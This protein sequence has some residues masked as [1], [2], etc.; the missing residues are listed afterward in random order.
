[1]S[2]S[3]IRQEFADTMLEVGRK[4]KRLVVLVGDI[5]HFRLQ[6]FAKACPGQYYNVGICEQTMVSMAVGLAKVGFYP[7]VH[8]IT[9]FIIERA[10]EQIK[11]DVGYQRIGINLIPIGSAFDYTG[12][13]CT[14]HSYGD[15]ALMKTIENMQIVYPASTIEFN[16]LF[17]QTYRNGFPTYIRIPAVTH[18]VSIPRTRIR[19]G[20]G[21]RVHGGDDLTIVAVGPLLKIAVESLPK[22]ID[23]GISTDLL[24]LPT[25]KPLDAAI[26][27]ASVGKT[28]RC[29]VI[30]EH[31]KYGGVYDDILRTCASAARGAI[32][33]SMNIGDRFIHQ[34]GTYDDFCR[35][36]GFTANG[37][38]STVRKMKWDKR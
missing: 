8:T 34:Y 2:G 26:L 4:D 1:M 6:P 9:P 21:I 38:V 27:R 29:L 5:D 23:L 24:Y 18:G 31:G 32:F 12:L 14:H 17:K 20:K 25:I 16:L 19:L 22:L 10:F 15:F 36:L 33:A 35:T 37:I 13:G 11:D 30:E 28:K 7:V 3:A